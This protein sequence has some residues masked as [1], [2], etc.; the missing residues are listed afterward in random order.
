MQLEEY[1]SIEVRNDLIHLANGPQFSIARLTGCTI[2]GHRFHTKDRETRRK[3]Q[4]SGVVVQAEHKGKLIDFYGVLTDILELKYAARCI[5]LIFKC[6]WWDIGTKKGINI[7]EFGFVSVNVCRKWYK[8]QPYVL[9]TQVQQV[10]YVNDLKLGKEWRVVQRSQPR[11]L[12]NIE[13]R[14]NE[15]PDDVD[16]YQQA[17]CTSQINDIVEDDVAGL[18]LHRNDT[19]NLCVNVEL[20]GS[21]EDDIDVEDDNNDVED[22]DDL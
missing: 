21:T 12:Y 20:E 15:L 8:D 7:D 2:N 5:V 19:G 3:T 9:A 11:N 16:P 18:L 10:F 22:D 13:L 1:E 17:E 6:D 4:N 14:S